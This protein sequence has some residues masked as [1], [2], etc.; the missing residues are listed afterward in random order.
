VHLSKNHLTASGGFEVRVANFLRR[1]APIYRRGRDAQPIFE[2]GRSM[3]T[4]LSKA[5][6]KECLQNYSKAVILRSASR[7]RDRGKRDGRPSSGEHSQPRWQRRDGT[8]K[9]RSSNTAG[10]TDLL[11][12][13][14]TRKRAF[15]ANDILSQ[16]SLARIAAMVSLFK[17]RGGGA[18]ESASRAWRWLTSLMRLRP[19]ADRTS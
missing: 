1:Q 9:S 12:V 13:L 15:L 18:R 6:T 7:G 14:N 11:T 5:V 16:I 2:G 10:S 8:T 4:R 17:A 3:G 19:A